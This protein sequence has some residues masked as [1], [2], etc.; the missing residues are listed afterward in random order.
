MLESLKKYD[1]LFV[2]F[3]SEM[4]FF[5]GSEKR[6]L[7]WTWSFAALNNRHG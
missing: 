7:V 6:S 1:Q 2:M 5:A 4:G 3:G